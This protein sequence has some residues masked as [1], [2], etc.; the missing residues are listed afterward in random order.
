MARLLEWR[1]AEGPGMRSDV[2]GG[3]TGGP[4]LPRRSERRLFA[5]IFVIAAA[6]VLLELTLT[7]IFDVVLQANLANLIV[8]SAIFGL[9]LG[10]IALMLWPMP[11]TPTHTILTTAAAAFAATVLLLVAV[12]KWLPFNLAGFLSEPGWQVFYF[13]LLCQSLLAPFFAAGVGVAT[14]LARHARLI[15]RL[16]FWDLVGAGLGALGILWLPTLI[17]PG[18]MLLLI[19]AAGVL[20]AVLLADGAVAR[21]RAGAVAFLGLVFL[22]VVFAGQIEFPSHTVKRGRGARRSGPAA[23]V[24]PVGPGRQDRCF[25]RPPSVR[26]A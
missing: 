19:A 16:Y 21:E 4:S 8:S 20:A 9:G 24:L 18:A 15:D 17:G 23:R 1:P 7:R 6:I 12:L 22:A 14:I 25:R 11:K 3:S 26:S 13:S 5:G 10:G 2:V